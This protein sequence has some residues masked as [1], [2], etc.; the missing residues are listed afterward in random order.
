MRSAAGSPWI[1]S[2]SQADAAMNLRVLIVG[3][4][5]LLDFGVTS[6][7][8]DKSDLLVAGVTYRGENDLLQKME[9]M[10][11]DIIVICE[12]DEFRASMVIDLLDQYAVMP[13]CRVIV[14]RLNSNTVDVCERLTISHGDDLLA[15]I[16][17]VDRLGLFE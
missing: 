1:D 8:T 13:T 9:E 17:K 6:L 7:L 5:T 12:S 16:R 14:T 2:R 10:R 11:P 15:I 3:V 4:G